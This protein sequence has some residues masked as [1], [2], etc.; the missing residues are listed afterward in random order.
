MEQN[1][2]IGRL[3]SRAGNPHG[4]FLAHAQ[5]ANNWHYE[6]NPSD[7]RV[8]HL[9]TLEVNA[10]G[11]VLKS[12]AI[13]YGRRQLNSLLPLQVDRDKQAKP[14]VTY[15]ENRVTNAIN[16]HVLPPDDYRTPLPCET[17]TLN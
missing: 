7:P 8:S 2:T 14:L 16:D 11:D 6:R 17:S 12:A 1:V 9:L 10:F 5:E 13:G 15:T 4:V 3:Q